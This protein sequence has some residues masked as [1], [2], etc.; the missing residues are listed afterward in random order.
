MTD[1]TK[2]AKKEKQEVA[3]TARPEPVYMPAVDICEDA[4]AIR[5]IA[6][7]PGADQ[8]SVDVSVENGVLTVEGNGSVEPPDGYELVGQEYAV[9]RFRRDFTLSDQVDVEGIKAKVNNG[10]LEL[11]IPKREEVKTRKI[12]I[13]S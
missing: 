13:T 4:N 1:D 12:E 9:G 6:D 7:M 3:E 5:L 10:V 11:T 2:I 8:K